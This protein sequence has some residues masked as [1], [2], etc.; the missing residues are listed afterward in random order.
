MHIYFFTVILPVQFGSLPLRLYALTLPNEEDGVQ[1]I[2]SVLITDSTENSLMQK[3][4]ITMW[5]L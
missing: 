2:L 5:Y 4:L 1:V 3:I